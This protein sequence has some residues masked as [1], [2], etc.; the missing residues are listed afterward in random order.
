M[1]K[2]ISDGI[3]EIIGFVRESSAIIHYFSDLMVVISVYNLIFELSS[4]GMVIVW[5]ILALTSGIVA[6][7]LKSTLPTLLRLIFR[8]KNQTVNFPSFCFFNFTNIPREACNSDSFT[9]NLLRMH[10]HKQ[11]SLFFDSNQ[12]DL[13]YTIR[14]FV[15]KNRDRS[16][17]EKAGS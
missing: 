10:L 9:S 5:L 16:V 2:T 14:L 4:I 15:A 13:K 7:I 8:K 1:S 6:E 17:N 11:V 3:K 12:K